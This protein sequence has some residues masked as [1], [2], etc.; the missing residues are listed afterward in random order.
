ASFPV[1]TIVIEQFLKGLGAMGSEQQATLD[2]NPRSD[3]LNAKILSVGNAL[4]ILP[5][6]IP[7]GA[8]GMATSKILLFISANATCA[9][10]FGRRET[11]RKFKRRVCSCKDSE[12]SCGRKTVDTS[13]NSYLG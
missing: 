1:S 13:P 4:Q 11:T 12:N 2:P 6:N 7:G 10:V 3:S 8:F 5:P 9:L